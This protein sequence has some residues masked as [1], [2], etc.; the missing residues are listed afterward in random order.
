MALKKIPFYCVECGTEKK[1]PP[2][3]RRRRRC[4]GCSDGPMDTTMRTFEA[5][6]EAYEEA[7]DAR[8]DRSL[9]D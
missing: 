6:P 2:A 7:R 5:D 8:G 3:A 1:C 4:P 9:H